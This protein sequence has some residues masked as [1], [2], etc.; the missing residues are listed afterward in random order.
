MEHFG[1]I[2]V[3]L[4]GYSVG[5][6]VALPNRIYITYPTGGE[7]RLLA[8]LCIIL[9]DKSFK[10]RNTGSFMRLIAG[11]THVV[12][13]FVEKNHGY[14]PAK[15]STGRISRYMKAAMSP[16]QSPNGIL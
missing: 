4:Y 5:R 6:A 11:H 8:L 16:R 15:I 2:S 9:P 7:G 3:M 13:F 10:I 12:S 1:A 14:I